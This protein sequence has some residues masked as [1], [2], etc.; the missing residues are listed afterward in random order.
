MESGK[1]EMFP[2]TKKWQDVNTAALCETIGEHLKTLEENM[3]FYFS[4]AFTERLDW[5]RDPYSST[6]VVGKHM[7]AGTGKQSY[8][9][10][11]PIA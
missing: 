9:D 6:S 2:L 4:S 8:F 3:S 10:I 7:T 11:A 1:L 5:V